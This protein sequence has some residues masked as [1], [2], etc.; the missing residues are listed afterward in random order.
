MN[1][2]DI[3]QGQSAHLNWD[4]YNADFNIADIRFVDTPLDMVNELANQ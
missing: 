2:A 1:N 3:E 4:D